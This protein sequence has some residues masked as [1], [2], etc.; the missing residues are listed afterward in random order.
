MET[1]LLE[2]STATLEIPCPDSQSKEKSET[3]RIR[4]V[5]ET[6]SLKKPSSIPTGQ[7]FKTKQNT[8]LQSVASK[9]ESIENHVNQRPT[10]K[11]R[12]LTSLITNAS[13]PRASFLLANNAVQ[14][15]LLENQYLMNKKRY[16]V[17]RKELNDKHKNAVQLYKHM[18]HLREKVIGLGA[19][20][21]GKLE[22]VGLYLSSEADK[23]YSPSI[24]SGAGEQPEIQ[25][26]D[27]IVTNEFVDTIKSKLHAILELY[28]TLCQEALDKRMEML[29]WLKQNV[30]MR[31]VD[32]SFNEINLDSS[33]TKQFEEFQNEDSGFRQKLERTK[34][35]QNEMIVELVKESKVLW[36]EYQLHRNK[37]QEVGSTSEV[38]LKEKLISIT[39]QLKVERDK[40]QQIMDQKTVLEGQMQKIRGKVRELEGKVINGEKTIQQL[41]TTVK[42]LESQVKQKEASLQ[43]CT[44]EMQKIAKSNETVIT[45][46]EKQKENLQSR[47]TEATNELTNN[48]SGFE[49]AVQETKQKLKEANNELFHERK[50]RSLVE[51]EL[52]K[53][54]E[55]Y[56][57]LEER[58]QTLL[59]LAEKTED[60]GKSEISNNS[61]N[62]ML[63]YNELQAA[64]VTIKEQENRLEQ[65]KREKD[66]LATVVK[67]AASREVIDEP[68]S[69]LAADL[70]AATHQIK[71]LKEEN[72]EL[73]RNF[74]KMHN[75]S[76]S[77]EKQLMDLHASFQ[78][79]SKEDGKTA[80][81]ALLAKLHQ[82]NLDLKCNLAHLESENEQ[83]GAE[84]PQKQVE[85]DCIKQDQNKLLRAREESY[86]KPARV[87]RDTKDGRNLEQLDQQIAAKVR[88]LQEIYI[89]LEN[90]KRQVTQLEEMVKQMELQQD[91]A[92]AQRT[93][94]ETRIAE[95]ELAAMEKNQR[96]RGFSIM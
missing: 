34:N 28:L 66:D 85:L 38:E 35:A 60:L 72:A 90:K 1:N 19:K 68:S 43:H 49:G 64:K 30:F 77:L 48:N 87:N 23:I 4:S 78:V 80:S 59:K 74:T 26:P 39:D 25:L 76:E 71:V 61:N 94:L 96:S 41:Q 50:N 56:V 79:Q 67:K 51:T 83:L 11:N 33:I 3:K 5:K 73:K 17:L 36:T 37:L 13:R 81:N 95:L 12:T 58:S 31:D 70:L 63:I 88:E 93:R 89:T 29:C 82:N 8:G 20:D 16:S 92:Q 55:R 9:M 14:K 75:K 65:F 54:K 86:I 10:S 24:V 27:S 18:S 47:L 84:L 40:A 91:R 32:E 21:P 52:A 6:R 42:Q 22:E 62:E 15:R 7:K 57:V 53:L 44:K 69:K 46:L 45:K 2:M